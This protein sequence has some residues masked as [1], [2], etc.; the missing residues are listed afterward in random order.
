MTDSITKRKSGKHPQ[1]LYMSERRS[2]PIR[3]DKGSGTHPHSDE[4]F[5]V[6]GRATPNFQLVS[7]FDI[8]FLIM[9]IIIDK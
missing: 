5:F 8:L 6:L 9:I 7:H 2:R 3:N 1:K 4:C